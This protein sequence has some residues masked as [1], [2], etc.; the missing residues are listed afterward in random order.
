MVPEVP[1]EPLVLSDPLVPE[2]EPPVPLEPLVPEPWLVWLWL[3][4]GSCDSARFANGPWTRTAVPKMVVSNAAATPTRRPV[5]DLR[6]CW[7]AIGPVGCPPMGWPL[8]APQGLAG[9]W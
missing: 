6:G 8:G 2:L 1:S 9:G 7:K 4:P 3:V 5:D